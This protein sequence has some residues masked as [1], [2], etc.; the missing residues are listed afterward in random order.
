M[1]AYRTSASETQPPR[2]IVTKASTAGHLGAVG[3]SV[4]AEL[5]AAKDAPRFQDVSAN[6]IA[7]WDAVYV[8]GVSPN[9]GVWARARPTLPCLPGEHDSELGRE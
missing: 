4:E 5:S 9:G 6:E 7:F 3:V 1:S 8:A 2:P